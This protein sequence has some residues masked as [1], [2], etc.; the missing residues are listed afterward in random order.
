MVAGEH[1]PEEQKEALERFCA[2]AIGEYLTNPIKQL[3][4]S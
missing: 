2:E 1:L 4:T 3:P